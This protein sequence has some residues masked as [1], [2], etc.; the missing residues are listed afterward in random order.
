MRDV[1][2]KNIIDSAP[3]EKGESGLEREGGGEVDRIL[4]KCDASCE[5][6]VRFIDVKISTADNET[7]I[8]RGI[9]LFPAICRIAPI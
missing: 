8:E 2:D 5:G 9:L 3:G 1:R 4:H 6:S 7:R